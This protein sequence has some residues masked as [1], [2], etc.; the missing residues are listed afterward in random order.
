MKAW[1]DQVANAIRAIKSDRKSLQLQNEFF[2]K[3]THPAD[4]QQ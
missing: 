3:S 2:D 4:T 1:T